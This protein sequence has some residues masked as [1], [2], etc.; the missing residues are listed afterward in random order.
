MKDR[1]TSILKTKRILVDIFQLDDNYRLGNSIN[2]FCKAL[3]TLHTLTIVNVT[4]C[5]THWVVYLK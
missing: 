4:L 5:R 1:G 2:V 3:N